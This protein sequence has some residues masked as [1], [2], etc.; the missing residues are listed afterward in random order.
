M[1]PVAQTSR[2]TGR[3]AESVCI[4]YWHS[5][6][7]SFLFVCLSEEIETWLL[8]ALTRSLHTTHP[9]I[10]PSK[11]ALLLQAGHISVVSVTSSRL[12]NSFS[13]ST[14]TRG[15][16]HGLLRRGSGAG[17]LR[18]HVLQQLLPLPAVNSGPGPEQRCQLMGAE[19]APG[20]REVCRHTGAL[21]DTGGG[22]GGGGV[23]QEEGCKIMLMSC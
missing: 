15:G 1:G 18:R 10:C 5:V 3:G 14:A 22:G 7:L 8:S 17:G 6:L 9:N 21:M 23:K 2:A 11:W 16:H 12:L 19:W 20:C 13:V 4:F